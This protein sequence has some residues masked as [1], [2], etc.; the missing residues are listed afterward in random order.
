MKKTLLAGCI[1]LSMHS[2]SQSVIFGDNFEM[3]SFNWE[4]NSSG[5][6]LNLWTVNATYTGNAGQSIADVPDQPL[7]FMNGPQSQYLHIHNLPNCNGIVPVTCNANFDPNETSNWYTQMSF[8]LNTSA[9]ANVTLSF[10]YLCGGEDNVSYGTVEYSTDGGVTWSTAGSPFFGVT[11]WTQIALTNPNFDGQST[12]R[13]RF[14]WTNGNQGIN[15]PFSID[16]IV[17]TSDQLTGETITMQHLN[18]SSYC[19]GATDAIGFEA[20]GTYN[21]GNVF[22]AQL[23]DA[24]GSFA[25]PVNIGTLASSSS[26][27]QSINGTFPFSTPAGTGY[28]V[29]VIASDPATIGGDNG[30]DVTIMALPT[31]NVTSV[32]ADGIICLGSSAVLTASGATTYQWSPS[33]SLDSDNGTTVTATPTITTMYTVTGTEFEGCTNTQTFTVTV[34][35]CAALDEQTAAYLRVYPNPANDEIHVQF[36]VADAITQIEL[37]DESG[38]I[39]RSIP[40]ALMD[41]G[42]DVIDLDMK[43]AD[44]QHGV[45]TVRIQHANGSSTTRFTKQ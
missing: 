37:L 3:P 21:A 20:L 23:S 6:G 15:P 34:E 9:D 39:I 29:R 11:G 30:E 32:P 10:W 19:P 4:I 8:D 25:S 41:I 24:S 16:E 43:I 36:E 28:R 13:F 5:S 31:I 26:G 14:G 44:L 2:F 22:T 1:A 18:A 35:D 38:R 45:Y 40:W 7:S 12:L 17:I 27:I 42:T 33:A